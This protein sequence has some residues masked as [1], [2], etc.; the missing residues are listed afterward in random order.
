MIGPDISLRFVYS[1]VDGSVVVPVVVPP[2][3]VDKMSHGLRSCLG[4]APADILSLFLRLLPAA[5]FARLRQEEKL[6][7]NNRICNAAVVM[8][9]M[10]EQR[11]QGN[12]TLESGVLELVRG[13][14]TDFRPRPCKR[15]LPGP[16]GQTPTLS[17]NTGSYNE[18]RQQLSVGVVEASFD[19]VFEQLAAE[20][21]PAGEAGFR[22]YFVD[23]TSVRTAHSEALYEAFPPGSNQHREAHWPLLR[24][25]VAH[26][27]HSGLALRPEW[28]PMNGP[29]AVSEQ[30]LPEQAVDRL[31]A[32]AVLV[33]DANFGIFPVAWAADR[34]SHPVILRL[35]TARAQRLAGGERQDGT[36]RR[37][38]WKPSRDDRR[39]H[40]EL[41]ADACVAGRLIVQQVQPGNGSKPFL[42]ALFDKMMYYVGQ[43]RLPKR[44]RQR[45][46]YPRAVWDK[47]QAFPK[48][49][50]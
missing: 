17:G 20:L 8:W 35:T 42:P 11:L 13:L 32:K 22:A 14:S 18:A 33:G 31:P 2:V 39:S 46:A 44:T 4:A 49:T 1:F 48:R 38:R 3:A 26:D 10:M 45:A 6:N 36:D 15:L 12:A 24:M 7:E 9:L 37:I 19:H 41:P 34:R 43:A 50:G 27:L 5:F 28:G 30:G 25:L 40:P 16:E 29:R 23:G 47:R 21:R